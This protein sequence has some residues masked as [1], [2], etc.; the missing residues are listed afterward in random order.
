MFSLAISVGSLYVQKHFK[1]NSKEIALE[2]VNGIHGIFDQ[3]LNT[4]DWMDSK[5][6]YEAKRKLKAMVSHIGYPDEM[7]DNEKLAEYYNKLDIDPDQYFESFLRMNT[8]GIDYSFSKLRTP[9]NKT[10][11]IRHSRPAIV[12]A[13]Y[14]SIENSI[15]E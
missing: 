14:S 2:M 8:F 5:T 10:G 7:L 12:N 15:R 4:V 13:F 3:I 11:W 6:K 1:Q 9:Y